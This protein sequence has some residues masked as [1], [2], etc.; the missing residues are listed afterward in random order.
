MKTKSKI[1]ILILAISFAVSCKSDSLPN[2]L[3]FNSEEWKTGDSRRRGRMAH[4]LQQKSILVNKTKFEVVELLGKPDEQS[5]SKNWLYRV[6]FENKPVISVTSQIN[7]S[8]NFDVETEKVSNTF[9]TGGLF[10]GIFTI[11]SPALKI[12]LK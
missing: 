9:F 4:D 3:P 6:N 8:V 5:N 10:F 11:I 12:F 1:L 7:L 2:N